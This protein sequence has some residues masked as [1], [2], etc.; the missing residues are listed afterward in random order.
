MPLRDH[1]HAPIDDFVPWEGLH[2]QWPAVIVQDL[3]KKLPP[4]YFAVPRIHV[5]QVEID[6]AAFDREG[7]VIAPPDTNG[8]SD[9]TATAVWAPARPTLAVETDAPENSDYEVQVYERAQGRRRLVAAVE[10]VSPAN[11]DRPEQ[12][13]RFVAK[14]ADLLR[15]QVA[16]AIVDIVTIRAFNL[17]ADLVN[18]LG[19]TDPS[20]GIEPAPL[21]AVSCRWPAHG[22]R[23]LLETWNPPVD[24]GK[25]LPTLPLWLAD[26]FAVPLDL[27]ETYEQTCRDLRIP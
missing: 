9:G 4:R 26:T 16:I 3:V 21:Y 24:L 23:R 19:Q 17:Y 11:K 18:V 14:C 1:F 6:V 5:G 22:E 10:L 13:Q 20:L 27:E 7:I 15:R 8:Q 25:T 12:R 2:G